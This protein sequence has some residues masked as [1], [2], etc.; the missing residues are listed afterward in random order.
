MKEQG[1]DG[2]YIMFPCQEKSLRKQQT[3]LDEVQ[4]TAQG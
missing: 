3:Q 2:S 1:M 4:V